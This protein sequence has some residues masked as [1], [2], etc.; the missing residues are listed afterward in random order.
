MARLFVEQN[1][2]EQA[3][4]HLERV[5]QRAPHHQK[6]RRLLEELAGS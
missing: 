2:A 1:M 3:R 4:T 6:A 5:L